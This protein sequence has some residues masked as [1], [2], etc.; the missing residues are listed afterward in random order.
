MRAADTDR[1]QVAEQLRSAHSEGRLDLAEYDDRVQQ[2]WAARTYGEL[3]AL[4]ADLPRARSA[5]ATV[6]HRINGFAVASLVVGT[7]WF[8]WIGSILALVFGYTARNQIR[9]R[10]ERGAGLATAGI[11]L[12]WV[13]VGTLAIILTFG[14]LVVAAGA[15]PAPAL[16][17]PVPLGG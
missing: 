1:E 10:G 11:M 9:K 7:M 14:L 3:K 13:G 5:V 4:T 2:A 16:A 15:D 6:Q 17:P 12:G 8:F